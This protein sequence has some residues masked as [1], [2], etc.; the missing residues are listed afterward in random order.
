MA[1][2]QLKKQENIQKMK[3][4]KYKKGRVGGSWW[5]ENKLKFMESSIEK[6]EELDR[7][8]TRQDY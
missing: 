4:F 7:K 8:K 1:L 3:Q 5:K 6:K 2:L